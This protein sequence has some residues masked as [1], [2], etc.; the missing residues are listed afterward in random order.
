MIREVSI[1][2]SAIRPIGASSPAER[3]SRSS[4]FS[5][6]LSP[7]HFFVT[8]I[9]FHLSLGIRVAQTR[10]C[11]DTITKKENTKSYLA[12]GIYTGIFS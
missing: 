9:P 4:I 8:P 11:L 2:T 6:T 10:D 7:V 3:E 1:L 5:K 12:A